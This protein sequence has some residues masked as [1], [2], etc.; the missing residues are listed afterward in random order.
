[1]K[2]YVKYLIGLSALIA[3]STV[4]AQSTKAKHYKLVWSDEFN[5][6]GLPDSNKWSYEQGFVRNREPQYYTVK[7]LENCRVENGMLVI[8]ARKERYPNA[9]YRPDAQSFAQK[10]PFASYT[11]ASLITKGKEEWTYGRMEIRAKVPKGMGSWPAFW[12]LGYDHDR[13]K[14]PYCGEID[15]MEFVGRDS[16]RVYGTAHYADVNGAYRHKGESPVVGTPFD[17]FHIY[18]VEWDKHQISFYYDNKKYF[19]FDYEHTQYATGN[20]FN[21]KYYLLLNLALGREGTLGGKLDDDI[22]PL[23]YYIDYV[24]VYQ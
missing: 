18:A 4:Q 24:R 22:L 9:A 19:V 5:Y 1:M 6:R 2:L 7:R 3:C 14:W 8:E 21:K 11:S 20:T 10:E 15:I 17:G 12:M 13:V 23:K 16:T